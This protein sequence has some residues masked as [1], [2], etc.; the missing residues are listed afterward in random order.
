MDKKLVAKASTTIQAP[1]AKVWDALVTPATI[2]QYMFGTTVASDFKKGSPITWKGEWQ[3]KK[4][5]DKG[6]ILDLQPKRRLAYSHFSPLS[7]LPEKPENFHNVTIE[8][9]DKGK[10][11]LVSLSQDNNANEKERDH[12]QKNWEMMLSGLKKLLES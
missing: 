5:E 3:G 2:K 4:Y 10:Q 8:L 12:S 7:G 9:V 11:T 1:A 6:V